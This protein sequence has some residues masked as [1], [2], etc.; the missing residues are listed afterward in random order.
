[1]DYLTFLIGIIIGLILN[2][3]LP[4]YFS[5]KEELLATKEDIGKITQEI[6]EIKYIYKNSY[7]L[8][9]TEKEFYDQMIKE[10]QK[11][12]AIIKEYELSTKK[13][14]NSLTYDEAMENEK[15]RKQTLDFK[16]KANEILARAFVFLKE[17]NYQSLKNSFKPQNNF[18]EIRYNLLNAMRQSIHRE[19]KMEASKDSIDIKY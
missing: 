1:M 13:G 12:L 18:A 15:L 19:T 10:L 17:E 2:R 6:E 14:E 11:F 8:S 3:F 9:K 16:E 5:K 7:D 4:A